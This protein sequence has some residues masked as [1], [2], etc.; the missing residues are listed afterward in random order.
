MAIPL[1]VLLVEDNPSDA[2][3][4]LYELRRAGFELD[5]RRAETEVDF[6]A[7]LDPT[8]DLILADYS[9]PHFNGLRALDLLVERGLEIP[10]ILIS[11]TIGEEVAV[12][13]IKRGA[14]DYLLKDR[15]GRLGAAV[16]QAL[17]KRA[18][19]QERSTALAALHE[20]ETRLHLVLK[21]SPVAVFTQDM[22]LRYTWIY[23]A[24]PAFNMETAL[25]KTD[26]E[27][28]SPADAAQLTAFKR[29]VL[30]TGASAREEISLTLDGQVFHQ[31]L[32]LD[33]LLDID[34]KVIGVAGVSVDITDRIEAEH[35]LR[36]RNDYLV[37][38]QETTLDLQ[39]Q[40]SLDALL[41]KILR[42]VGT[43]MDTSS[44][45]LDLVDP[46]RGQLRPQV[47]VGELAE[48]LRHI[49]QPGKG[50][51]GIVW[52]TK[53]P[54]AIK[55]YD[56][57]Q[58]RPKDF[59]KGIISSIIGVPLMGDSGIFGVLGLGHDYP[60]PRSFDQ[61]DVDILIQFGRLAALAI[62][63]ARLYSAAQQELAE[64]KRAEQQ[65][66]LQ[67][68]ALESAANAIVITDREGAIQWVN[69]AF[70]TLTGYSAQEALAHNP[71]D[72]VNSGIHDQSFFENLWNTILDGQV[73]H[74]EITNRRKDGTLYHEE[75]TITPVRDA[76]GTIT[77]FV[78]IKQDISERRQ[79]EELI[80]ARLALL[81]YS[82][83]HGLQEVLRETLD[84]V[85][86]LTNSPIGFYHFVEEDQNSLSLQAW[87]TLTLAEYCHAA[88]EG[89][90]YPID[91]AGVWVDCV[92]T[93]KP[94]VHNDYA[95]LSHR[96]GLPEGHA[97]LFRELVVPIL[98]AD[99]VVAIL[100]VGNKPTDYTENDVALV[101]YFADVVWEIAEQK[102]A[103]AEREQLMAQIRVQAKQMEQV[104]AT[105]PSGVLM[106]DSQG[107][108]LQANPLAQVDLTLL[109][110]AAV[111]EIIT[112]LGDR[113]LVD[114][115]TSPPTKGLWHEIQADH[116]IFEAMS[117]PVET[118][119]TTEHWVLV[120]NETTQARQ[121][122]MQLQQQERLAAV[123]QLAAGIAHDFN[124]IMAVIVLY[125]QMVARSEGISDR[126]REK[127]E[128]INQQ[129]WHASRLIQQ[130]LD[131]SRRSILQQRP[132]DLLPL[133]KEQV[134]LLEHT[135]PDD[136]VVRLD[137]G[138]AEYTIN[139]DPTRI[140]QMITNLAINA[141]DA[142]P[143]GGTLHIDLSRVNIQAIDAA[144]TPIPGAA[145]GVE[146][147]EWIKLTL[148]DTGM[149]IP[150]DILPHIFDPFFTTKQ[151]GSG[152][153]L[154]LAQV[155][156]IV[157]Q[158]G[159]HIAVESMVGQGT[160]FTIHLPA[161]ASHPQEPELMVD[162]AAIPQGHGELLLVVEDQA[163]VR[164]AVV[165]TLEMVGYQTIEAENG[166][167]ALEI[168]QHRGDEVAL[169]LSDVVM[170]VMGG[171][172]LFH[173][174]RAQARTTPFI[175]L[176]GHPLDDDVKVL[177]KEGLNAWL[178]KPPELEQL[179]QA[180]AQ[181][182][183][184][185]KS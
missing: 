173:T 37:A 91:Q 155:H 154:G 15:L 41:E 93:K 53:Q 5:T 88:G 19:K 68:T 157:G 44:G 165:A 81:E 83:T 168:M 106:L 27:R 98:R 148:K 56:T 102:R 178:P 132:L 166:K 33:P 127:L 90:H 171:I 176:T 123:G 121:I 65:V 95:T 59:P 161:L 117:R 184:E 136:V 112:H 52:Q 145:V 75:Q 115:L 128:T 110:G 180:I 111:G 131:F 172:V 72:L 153:G 3:L 84:Q 66:I 149:G 24:H 129:A 167:E 108:I 104:L 16:E 169:I 94:V 177:K 4:M 74:G 146:A 45:F 140:Q 20:S 11:G 164:N 130:L 29:G 135:L 103:E 105:V 39:S 109:A 38:L 124:N 181:A 48:S 69:P 76:Q 40:L 70:S 25:G 1:H 23:N 118:G 60:D 42:R 86:A 141:R 160:T 30:E 89:L 87:S 175:M 46:E 22:D 107:R 156:G 63:N 21:N 182:L 170:P 113:S 96:K 101:T 97:E 114:L 7:A 28:F 134:K 61:E 92:Y 47:G 43:L 36:R 126:N 51:A 174:L 119:S 158:H 49:T 80:R 13:A 137:C 57:W 35:A 150:P 2:E 143:T 142:M 116:R 152:T 185:A 12:T 58:D 9:L 50:L 179:A 73:W 71:R 8:L 32:S 183:Q 67:A 64:R 122:Q 6:L 151:V 78:A 14:T 54:L 82:T 139:A 17:H 31:D 163:F 120:L 62:E 79:R 99:K 159:G 26:E 144:Q 147:G 10:F 138:L 77:H 34:G 18:L 125:A 100:G 133:L 55:D 162:M 85:D